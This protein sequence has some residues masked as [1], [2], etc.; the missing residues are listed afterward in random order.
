MNQTLYSRSP[1]FNDGLYS[2]P[3]L[4]S[5]RLQSP[6]TNQPPLTMVSGSRVRNEVRNDIIELAAI[7]NDNNN[8]NFFADKLIKHIVEY[9]ESTMLLEMLNGLSFEMKD[10]VLM[11]VAFHFAYRLEILKL[12]VPLSLY[13]LLGD[14][15]AEEHRNKHI[16]HV[17]HILKYM[18][19]SDLLTH[20]RERFGDFVTFD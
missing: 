6:G 4:G 10:F 17:L 5:L 9:G 11:K 15:R 13:S 3:S 7:V 19:R 12:L 16:K 14:S 1:I 2:S 18:G 8:A 20:L